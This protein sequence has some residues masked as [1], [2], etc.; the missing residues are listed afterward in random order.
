MEYTIISYG[1]G[2]ILDTMFN[3]IAALLN[4]KTGSI[5]T[6]MIRMGLSIGLLWATVLMIF[7]QRMQFFTNWMIPFFLI[8]TLFFAPTCTVIIK[9][10]VTRQPPYIVK[11]VP[12]GLGAFAGTVSKLS[13]TI[14]RKIEAV[15]SLPD[16]LKY[17]KTGAVMASNLIAES[18]S[19]H[20]TNADL[21]ATMREFVNQ[22]VV[23]DALAG[24]KY[25]MHDLRTSDDI[26]GLV[27]QNA[28]PARCFKFKAPERGAQAKICTCKEGVVELKKYLNIE[29]ENAFQYFGNKFFSQK[30]QKKDKVKLIN[31][32][33][34]LKQFLP[35]SYSYMANM[36]KSASDIM[37]QQMMI[38]SVIDSIESKS[39]E[40]GNAP[41]FAV[42]RA[43]LQQ[44]AQQETL[45]GIA[46][47]KLIAMKNVM[48]ALIYA[49]FIFIFPLA[50]LP[51][52]WK[53]IARWGGLLLWVH[54]WPPLYAV[55]NFIMNMAARSKGIGMVTLGEGTGVTIANSVGF[56][57]FH[58]D[59]AAQ[60]GFMS[61]AIGALAYA[62]V[63]G[64]AGSFVHLAN[65]L[66]GPATMA[67]SR[68]AEDLISGNYSF[69][70]VSQGVMQANNST[71]GQQMMSPSY[72]SGSFRQSD[73]HSE[74]NTTV[75]GTQ[76]VS[77]AASQLQR[78]VSMN[79]SVSHASTQQASNAAQ[80][81]ENK[82]IAAAHSNAES[83]RNAYDLSV[84]QGRSISEGDTHS[85]SQGTSES[86]AF[87]ELQQHVD[88]F[89]TDHGISNEKASNF[90]FS[91]SAAVEGGIGFSFLG[92]GLTAKASV[93]SST[94]WRTSESDRKTFS[95]AMDYAK[96]E[97][98]QDSLSGVVSHA[99][100]IRAS[101]LTDEG[102]KYHTAMNAASEQ[103]NQLRNEASA[104]YQKSQSYSEL[105]SK[106][107]QHGHQINANMNQEYFNWLQQQPLSNSKG[108]MGVQEA[109]T[110]VTS[111]P[112]MD[113]DY[114][115]SFIKEKMQGV[116][117]YLKN[118][119][120]TSSQQQV[121]A[122]FQSLASGMKQQPASYSD[123]I[124]LRAQSDGFGAAFNLRR[125]TK[126][127]VEAKLKE[128][129]KKLRGHKTQ[130]HETLRQG[131]EGFDKE[132]EKPA[133]IFELG[134][135]RKSPQEVLKNAS[136]NKSQAK[137]KA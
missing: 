59:M 18:R 93:G 32:S 118:D 58:A 122:A 104:S 3:A 36:A 26:W 9:D 130:I 121:E 73:G 8:L 78:S 126:S 75:Y 134:D 15:F 105:A 67:A 125:V 6:S 25:T 44:R 14:T 37:M 34:E 88:K 57:N 48:E 80:T 85:I 20:I 116:E 30:G 61:I 129:D 112:D 76:I 92:N 28:S 5:Y 53:F 22:C 124:Q 10:P 2:E 131:R 91:A 102:K 56:M 113:R 127:T 84:I 77:V 52:G 33:R 81:A 72:H 55:L 90:L 45:A 87:N 103:S 86:R 29:V 114:Q 65:H 51:M 7:G 71:F 24:R 99:K 38:Y 66:G 123:Q 94:D 110:I 136:W 70:N 17:H 47:Q 43:Y 89:A 63:K 39:T 117:K 98:F 133:M 137:N 49:A 19:Y 108:V 83:Y 79:E 115:K 120:F 135:S 11:H 21:L 42:R 95:D 62:L 1:A 16:D 41:N 60:A 35:I 74:R 97:G 100:D 109:Q 40:L 119:K 128:S 101:E 68:A 107:K 31:P 13:D 82:S 12:L 4:S 54:L 27:S 64:G 111:R 50:M 96:Q 106:A 23:Y 46:G 69:G 132:K